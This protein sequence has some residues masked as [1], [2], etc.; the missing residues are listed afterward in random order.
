MQDWGPN[1]GSGLEN[2]DAG[3]EEYVVSHGNGLTDRNAGGFHDFGRV[4]GTSS[5]VPTTAEPA[6]D[7]EAFWSCSVCT[8]DN[9]PLIAHCEMCDSAR[10]DP[11]SSPHAPLPSPMAAPLGPPTVVGA[12]QGLPSQHHPANPSGTS[13]AD[14]VSAT[15]VRSLP[16]A[17]APR[18]I[19]PSPV[20]PPPS[21]NNAEA[22]VPVGVVD[23]AVSS[24]PDVNVPP[25]SAGRQRSNPFLE[26]GDV[27]PKVSTRRAVSG[28]GGGGGAQ[29]HRAVPAGTVGGA[30]S[31]ES[32]VCEGPLMHVATGKKPRWVVLTRK[33]L[34]FYLQNASEL[35]ATVRREHVTTVRAVGDKRIHIAVAEPASNGI[36]EVGM[37]VCPCC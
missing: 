37:P 13:E 5:S 34:M 18:Q 14:G 24:Y 4:P 31:T 10:A 29:W 19:H 22:R 32:L 25:S 36:T 15:H 20:Q 1:L 16:Q 27:S 17:H 9:H 8:Y 28:N 21:H 23:A 30:G 2:D 26:C 7:S 12:A 3:V 35:M 11:V 33:K 6:S